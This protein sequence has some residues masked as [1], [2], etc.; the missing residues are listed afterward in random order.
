M[1]QPKPSDDVMDGL[2]GATPGSPQANAR[3]LRPD[4]VR[5]TQTSDDAVFRPKSDGGL[6]RAE[7][8]AAALRIAHLLRDE[9]LSAHYKALLAPLDGGGRLVASLAAKPGTDRW[10]RILAHVDRV[11]LEPGASEPAHIGL[12]A[13]AGLSPQAIVAL[14]QLIAYVNYQARVRAGLRMLGGRP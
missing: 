13:G 14:A 4:V 10:G 11:T 7:R 12:L 8:A 1:S 5:Y 3:G 9:T 6:T 2:S